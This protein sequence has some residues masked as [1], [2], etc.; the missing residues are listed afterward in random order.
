MGFRNFI[1]YVH[2]NKINGH[3]YVGCTK[4]DIESR[5]KRHLKSARTGS[6]CAFHRAIRKYGPD[7]FEHEVIEV[8]STQSGAFLAEK[9]W[10]E[11]FGS[12]VPNGYNLSTGGEGNPGLRH[13]DET[14]ARM[15]E[16]HR[17]NH[18][19]LGIKHTEETR[20]KMSESRTGSLNHMTGK[21][22]TEEAKEKLR[23]I[24]LGKRYGDDVRARMSESQ[25]IRWAAR[26]AAQ[27]AAT[28]PLP[29]ID[30]PIE[31]TVTISK[32]DQV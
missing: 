14:R 11:Q 16:S 23:A 12:V 3:R 9:L 20:A 17:G 32:D 1:V 7:A 4:L 21:H 18:S 29:N 2:T 30:P 8:L 28:L 13:T 10:I 19:R 5:W 25:R 22:H 31:E 26:K 24:N 27:A 6:E 15:S